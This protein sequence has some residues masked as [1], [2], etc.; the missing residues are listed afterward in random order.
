MDRY[1]GVARKHIEIYVSH[2]NTHQIES[3]TEGALH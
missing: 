1:M 3:I 2:A